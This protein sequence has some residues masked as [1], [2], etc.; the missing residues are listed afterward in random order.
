MVASRN[1]IDL[2]TIFDKSGYSPIMYAAY[3]NYE[4][5]V[6]ILIDFV[7]RKGEAA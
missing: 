6:Q 5:A 2:V 3:K 1:K 4:R 7:L